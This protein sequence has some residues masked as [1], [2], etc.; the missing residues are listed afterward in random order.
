MAVIQWMVQGRWIEDSEVDEM[1]RGAKVVS[2]KYTATTKPTMLAL[3]LEG[4]RRLVGRAITNLIPGA[5]IAGA[6][7]RGRTYTGT[8]HGAAQPY[9]NPSTTG[10][11]KTQT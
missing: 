11:T 1:T 8:L 4:W 2:K 10:R 7:R 5:H 6:D 3:N 9:Q